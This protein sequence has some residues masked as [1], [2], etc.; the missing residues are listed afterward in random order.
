MS[1]WVGEIKEKNK[2]W[3]IPTE[4]KAANEPNPAVEKLL[5]RVHGCV[6][7]LQLYDKDG[8]IVR[9]HVVPLSMGVDS[10]NARLNALIANDLFQMD[11]QEY[12]N[13]IATGSWGIG[14]ACD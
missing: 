7:S 9:R 8:F 6:I 10:E 4:D 3:R 11:S 5:E 12:S 1:V 14:W 13:L 2:N